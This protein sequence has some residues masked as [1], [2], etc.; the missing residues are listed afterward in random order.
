MTI[1]L[2]LVFI[3]AA[4]LAAA[5]PSQSPIPVA[6]AGAAADIAVPLPAISGPIAVQYVQV[7]YRNVLKSNG[8]PSPTSVAGSLLKSQATSFVLNVVQ[9]VIARANPLVGFLVN[10]IASR[11]TSKLTSIAQPALRSQPDIVVV[12]EFEA[13]T[14]IASDRTRM[15]VASVS[16]IV[17][18]DLNRVLVLDNDAKTY[19]VAP[20]TAAVDDA[21]S[22]SPMD[23]G[24][25]ASQDPDQT[26]SEQQP[27]DET[28]TIAGMLA[29]HAIF[30][31]PTASGFG[32]SHKTDLWYADVPVADRCSATTNRITQ[33]HEPQ[34]GAAGANVRIPLRSVE[35]TQ[36]MFAA[37][38]PTPS[39]TGAATQAYKDPMIARPGFAW[40]EAT[41][42]TQMSY[43]PTFFDIPAGYTLTTPNP[44]ETPTYSDTPAPTA[45]PIP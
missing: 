35:W 29:H 5:E 42:V 43:D 3:A 34:Y 16:T 11:L 40:M 44:D 27:D 20:L 19:A 12:P 41:S 31:A 28:E 22:D 26:T 45:S 13:T 30:S 10:K 33:V 37:A 6:P 8:M 4:A 25:G 17:Q 38:A 39:A 1:C 23:S 24:L 14:T 9:N 18:C 36:M 7:Q 15:D 32:G 21:S 2:H